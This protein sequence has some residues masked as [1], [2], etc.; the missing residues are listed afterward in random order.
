MGGI[1]HIGK[2]IQV[3]SG[4]PVTGGAAT[5]TAVRQNP[6]LQALM[7]FQHQLCCLRKPLPFRAFRQQGGQITKL[8]ALAGD[9]AILEGHLPLGLN[10]IQQ[11]RQIVNG[12]VGAVVMP[13]IP[14]RKSRLL[15]C[16]CKFQHGFRR[17]YHAGVVRSPIGAVAAVLPL[18]LH[19]PVCQ[20][21]CTGQIFF[22]A[23]QFIKVS[24]QGQHTG[25]ILQPVW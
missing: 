12:P 7:L 9:H 8:Q 20:I 22:I 16:Q 14:I 6:L 15:L 19:Q 11:S 5:G 21:V 24:Q 17:I 1:E 3:V 13:L 25:G 10:V 23:G 18:Q 2:E 4:L